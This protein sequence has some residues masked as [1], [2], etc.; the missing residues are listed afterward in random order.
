MRLWSDSF[1]NDTPIPPE[2]ALCKSDP[3]PARHAAYSDN[4]N[5]DLLWSEVPGG[6]RSFALI[7]H[8]RD[9]PSIRT[10]ANVEDKRLP[11]DLARVEFFH[12]VLVDIPNSMTSIGAGQFSNG[13]TARGKPGPEIAGE[14]GLRHGTNDYTHSFRGN[15]D[16]EGTYYGYDGPCPPWNDE[17]VHHY[18]FTLYALD[19]DRVPV[20]GKFTGQQV[21]SA[22]QGHVLAEAR[23]VG[24]YA[25]APG[26][27]R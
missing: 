2:F 12:W 18:V 4:R 23:L 14:P 1:A 22:L 24:T 11:K 8:D 21:R 25:T 17:R 15:P 9:A 5:P 16:M 7:C 10:D 19:I 6:T 13:V 27:G 26:Q 3:N 20:E